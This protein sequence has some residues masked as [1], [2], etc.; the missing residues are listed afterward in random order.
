MK[1]NWT[2]L[3]LFWLS[4]AVNVSGQIQYE[5]PSI[6]YLKAP[7]DNPVARLNAKIDAGE[8]TLKWEEE[9]GYLKSLLKELKIPISSQVLVFSQTSLQLRKIHPRK[10][11]ALYFNDDV[12]VGFVQRGDVLEISAS[13]T[14]LGTVFYTLDQHPDEPV[15]M[16]RDRGVCLTCHATNRTQGVPGHLVR[17]VFPDALGRPVLASGTFTTDHTSDFEDR[18]GG[19][20]VTGT[21][22]AMRHMGNTV[23]V[24][25][26]K[27]ESLD[28]NKEPNRTTLEG[29]VDTSPYLT[30]H[31]D[32]IALMVLE[33]QTQM[34]NR[35]AAATLETRIALNQNQAMN[36]AL[37]RGEDYLSDSTQR[38]I[39]SVASKLVRYLLFEEEFLLTDPLK[40]T[41]DFAA[42]FSQRGP[43][44]DKGRSLRQLEMTQR[45]FQYPCSFLIY[46]DAFQQM[47]PRVHQRVLT[48]LH[49][50]LQPQGSEDTELLIP[51]EQLSLEMRQDIHEILLSTHQQY[52]KHVAP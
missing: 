46:S 4:A 51:A 43:K 31:S 15:T 45:M 33:H 17:S 36:E 22:G 35:I 27:A 10:P 37:D 5:H 34:H 40:G 12:Y 52:A 30:P 20:Y 16:L 39:E 29:L 38:R 50:E 1:W 32:L 44:D 18:W 25:R 28:R 48:L 14:K 49:Q 11:R 9:Q 24:N 7:A 8:V 3:C 21:H 2:L 41:S 6:D 23:A 26:R 47:P 13:D 19:W 42:E